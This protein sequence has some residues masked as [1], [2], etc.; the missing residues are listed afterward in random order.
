MQG[1]QKE[2]QLSRWEK[3]AQSEGSWSKKGKMIEYWE[4]NTVNALKGQGG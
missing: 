2:R 1:G 3:N 4:I